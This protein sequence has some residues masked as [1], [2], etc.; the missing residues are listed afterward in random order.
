MKK[1]ILV[2]ILAFWATSFAS[3]GI[4]IKITLTIGKKSQPATCPNFGFCEF[5]HCISYQDGLI[6]GTLDVNEERSSMIVSIYEKDILKVQPDKI[7]YFKGKNYITFTEDFVLSSEINSAVRVKKP[8][9]IKKGEFPLSYK[10]GIYSIE[11]P[12]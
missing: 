4:V 1:I 12:L 11:I 3:A 8:L 6:N 9:V 5:I 7:D 2:S 10:N